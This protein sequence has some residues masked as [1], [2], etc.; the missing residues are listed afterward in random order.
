MDRCGKRIYCEAD[1]AYDFV[2]ADGEHYAACQACNGGQQLE[3]G[4]RSHK[5]LIFINSQAS[6][7]LQANFGQVVTYRFFVYGFSPTAN[8]SMRL[9]EM[10]LTGPENPQLP[11]RFADCDRTSETVGN[12]KISL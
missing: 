4:R 9:H 1:F 11:R 3:N 2:Q 10:G 12:A 6:L 8:I 5:P 7:H